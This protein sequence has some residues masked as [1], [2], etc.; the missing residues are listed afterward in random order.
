MFKKTVNY[1]KLILVSCLSFVLFFSIFTGCDQSPL[2]PPASHRDE[3]GHWWMWAGEDL[4]G[5]QRKVCFS[6]YQLFSRV[7][8]SSQNPDHLKVD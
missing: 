3:H 7:S 5:I 8:I 4:P 1:C 2:C 6:F